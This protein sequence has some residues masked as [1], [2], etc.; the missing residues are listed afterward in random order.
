MYVHQWS[1]DRNNRMFEA[2]WAA[3]MREY[4]GK[5]DVI[6]EACNAAGPVIVAKRAGLC[7]D[8]IKR[9]CKRDKMFITPDRLDAYHKAA[10]QVLREIEI[11]GTAIVAEQIR[12]AKQMNPDRVASI[13]RMGMPLKPYLK[14]SLRIIAGLVDEPVQPVPVAQVHTKTAESPDRIAL[15]E[16][17]DEIQQIERY[18]KAEL[19]AITRYTWHRWA[20]RESEKGLGWI[21]F[22]DIYALSRELRLNPTRKILAI[23]AKYVMRTASCAERVLAAWRKR[24]DSGE[25]LR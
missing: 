11:F 17:A 23:S 18:D 5:R 12:V 9:L 3:H 15:S 13:L 20:M 7:S 1:E 16:I 14:R 4:K 8:T 19:I 10:L 6:V 22:A 2:Q 24:M 25:A 21:G